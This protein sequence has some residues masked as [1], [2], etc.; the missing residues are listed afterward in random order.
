MACLRGQH[1]GQQGILQQLAGC[2]GL[3][4]ACS[5]SGIA[6]FPSEIL[7]DSTPILRINP[8]MHTAGIMHISTD[9]SNRFLVSASLDKTVRVWELP[10]GKLLRTLRPRI[11]EDT[12]AGVLYAVAI[13]PNARVV[14]TGGVYRELNLFDRESGHLIKMIAGSTEFRGTIQHLA[15]SPDGRFLVVTM[16]GKNG[17]RVYETRGYT[18]IGQDTDYGAGTY[19][20]EF[21]ARGRLASISDDGYIRLYEIRTDRA[22]PL[23]LIIKRSLAPDRP[24][25]LDFSPDARRIAVGFTDRP[26]VDVLSA[27]DLSL[28][29]SPDVTN[30]PSGSFVDSVAWSHNGR[31][32]Y[33]GG[34]YQRYGNTTIRVWDG[35]GEGAFQDFQDIEAASEAIE[36]IVALNNGSVVYA[37]HDP[38]LLILSVGGTVKLLSGPQTAD[39]RKMAENDQFLVS[40]DAASVQFTYARGERTARFTL[41]ERA[42]SFDATGE[43]ELDPPLTRSGF[44]GLFSELD[45]TDWLNN[46]SPK[47]NG[48]PLALGRDEISRSLA[49]APD[50]QSFLLGTSWGLHL[51][52]KD[53][54]ERWNVPVL[55]S[56]WAVNIARQKL[57]V[58]AALSDGTIA[59]YRL[60][61]KEKLLTLF[62]HADQKRWVV[63]TPKGYFD[64]SEADADKLIGWHVNRGHDREADF[65]FAS[66]MFEQFYDPKVVAEVLRTDELDESVLAK[67]GTQ[68]RIN[69][70]EAIKPPPH[71]QILSPETGTVLTRDDVQVIVQAEDRGSGVA[72]IRLYHNDKLVG[73]DTRAIAVVASD[74]IEKQYTKRF[75]VELLAGENFLHAIAVS[76]DR[77][78][79][80]SDKI[81]VRVKE[82]APPDQRAVLHLVAIGINSYEN[83]DLNLN[84]AQPDAEGI[85]K[86]FGSAPTKLFK[87]IKRY[88]L[89][90]ASATRTA[91]R[92]QLGALRDT[93]PED[94]V[95]IYLA[96][97]GE[98]VGSTWYFVPYE[99]VYPERPEELAKKGLSSEEM[100]KELI[101]QIGAKKILLLMDACKSG[102]AL[103]FA[104]GRPSSDKDIRRKSRS[105][106]DRKALEQ[107][108]R[109]TGVHLVAASTDEQLASEIAELGHGVFTY[110]LLE[111]LKGQ[112]DGSPKD[113]VVTVGEVVTYV[114]NQLPEISKKYK[115]QKQY[116]VMYR[117][118]MDFPLAMSQ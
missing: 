94:V 86:F 25:S 110:T 33:A 46:P 98:S 17:I 84:F 56:V 91:I 9:P 7:A 99:V 41:F 42:L 71:V 106:D 39:F 114:E 43:V 35:N 61:D 5:L 64:R 53:G 24:R 115:T 49:I 51:F 63:W 52:D 83:S 38:A 26:R 55:G 44:F 67:F 6:C 85:V 57:I 62:P 21:D 109:A 14:A 1:R 100:I 54:R 77:I 47:L 113:G 75:R 96:G 89:F 117:Q 80:Q 29:Y 20:A 18:L 16:L 4:G 92:K 48:R 88:E 78:E 95:V 40:P 79:G 107:L 19:A 27:Q 74:E 66:Q 102:A 87:T 90:N 112:A 69:T 22:V 58:V 105:L 36:D 70:A 3:I 116:P 15:Y 32:L 8:E 104:G 34:T 103:A 72:E 10:T 76:P 59:W 97:H 111:G 68:E 93:A 118:G 60:R 30:I 23:K 37:T 2:M 65:I 82:A 31:F 101:P 45:V 73:V 108:G 81:V 13:S 12:P 28:L 11:G 50:G